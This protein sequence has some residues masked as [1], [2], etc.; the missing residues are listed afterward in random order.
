MLE[1]GERLLRVD[2]L[3]LSGV[4]ESASGSAS[5]GD[6]GPRRAHGVRGRATVV[7]FGLARAP[8]PAEPRPADAALGVRTAA[9]GAAQ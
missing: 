9:G 8:R 7:G 1:S 6:A 2:G 3:A 5:G 4:S